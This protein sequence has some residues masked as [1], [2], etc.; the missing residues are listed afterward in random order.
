MLFRSRMYND[1]IG[2]TTLQ[3]NSLA[4]TGQLVGE[5]SIGVKEISALSSG[6]ERKSSLHQE[7]ARRISENSITLVRD[8]LNMLPLKPERTLVITV[9][10]SVTTIAD[11]QLTQ[12]FTLGSALSMVYF[13]SGARTVTAKVHPETHAYVGMDKNFVLDLRKAHFF[14]PETELAIGRE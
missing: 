5:M 9:A 12:T 14:D 6:S 10:T 1:F 7:V 8:Q 2:G 3:N 13:H 4:A 11:E